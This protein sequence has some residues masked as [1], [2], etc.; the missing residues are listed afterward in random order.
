MAQIPEEQIPREILELIDPGVEIQCPGEEYTHVCQSLAKK[1]IEDYIN[2]YKNPPEHVP[3]K[4]KHYA[5]TVFAAQE[6]VRL[7][8]ED[9]TWV[10]IPLTSFALASLF[11]HSWIYSNNPL[12]FG[13]G[14]RLNF[15]ADVWGLGLGGGALWLGGR[16][17]PAD[18]VVGDA[19]FFFVTTPV[20]T[21]ITFWKNDVIV[22]TLAGIGLNLQTG[23]FG[24]VGN[25]SRV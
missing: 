7:T 16:M 24:G 5:A 22:G 23:S 4:V 21:I 25:F 11:I 1:T 17:A 3:E 20:S 9:D 13:N 6:D 19:S 2:L 15:R 8:A 12:D 14:K 18:I 10:N